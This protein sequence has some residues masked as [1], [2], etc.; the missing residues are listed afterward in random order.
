MPAQSHRSSST[1]TSAAAGETAAASNQPDWM[2]YVGRAGNAAILELISGR[3]TDEATATEL[4][5][6]AT[7][8][9]LQDVQ[10]ERNSE[11]TGKVAQVKEAHS[12]RVQGGLSLT[13]SAGLKSE[14]ASFKEHWAQHKARYEAVAAETGFP[15]ELIAA[16]HWRECSGS[17]NK[18]LHQGD[19]LGKPAVNHPT[20]IP[21]FHDWHEAAV[22]ALTMSDKAAHRDNLGITE[23]TRDPATLATFAEAYNGLGYHNRGRVSPYVYSGTDAYSSGKYVSDGRFSSRTVD[24]QL[25]VITMMGAVG[26]MDI[27]LEELTEQVAWKRV[28]AGT[29]VLE[30]GVSGKAA[31]LAVTTLQGLLKTSGQSLGIDGDFGPGTE[32]ALKA[33]QSGRG[34]SQTG[35][36]DADT[37][38]ALQAVS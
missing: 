13:L 28:E 19:P 5:A 12:E 9:G 32:R 22:H 6:Q 29:L 25:G 2:S 10:V 26:G 7:S 4:L 3:E 21:V 33:F 27:A 11:P 23:D 30:R 14:L 35:I 16:I 17:F 34:L 15:A 37:L 36:V 18:Y 20:D 38:D 8:G 31:E 1:S 24:K